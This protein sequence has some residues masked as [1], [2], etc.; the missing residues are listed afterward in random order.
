MKTLA[1]LIFVAALVGTLSEAAVAGPGPQYWNRSAAKPAT[2][3]DPFRA[4]VPVA[5]SGLT[6][7]RMFVPK[8][9]VFKQAPYSVVTCTPE[10]MKNDWRCQQACAAAAKG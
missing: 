9:A 6:C 8:G 3:T 5:S 4:A 2:V 7:S 10:M 1:K